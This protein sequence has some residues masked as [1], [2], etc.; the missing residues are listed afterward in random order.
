MLANLVYGPRVRRS[1]SR[2]ISLGAKPRHT[3][4]GAAT[5]LLSVALVAGMGIFGANPAEATTTI[6]ASTTGTGTVCTSST[7]CSLTEALSSAASGASVELYS[8]TYTGN[9]TLPS[10]TVEPVPGQTAAVQLNGGGVVGQ[11]VIA[12]ET[13]VDATIENITV[14]NGDGG[15]GGAIYNIGTLTV[16]GSTIS[17]STATGSNGRVFGGGIYNGGTLTVETSTIADNTATGDA[18]GGIFNDAGASVTIDSSTIAGNVAG[19]D[20]GGIYNY[21]GTLTVEDS[22]ISGNSARPYVAAIANGGGTATVE[23]STLSSNE[24]GTPYGQEL[25][26]SVGTVH[27]CRRYFRYTWRSTIERRV[28]WSNA[29]RR[30]VQRCRR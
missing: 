27:P 23:S 9:F 1:R 10:V 12:V 26:T 15:W 17:D 25:N 20:G 24:A 19:Y 8:G 21:D 4:G 2:L 3:I 29:D 7:P 22:T 11:S 13:G 18:G 14:T 30:R 5:V 16:I 28:F 6:Y